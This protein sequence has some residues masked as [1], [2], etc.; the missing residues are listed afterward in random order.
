MAL[1]GGIDVESGVGNVL[2]LGEGGGVELEIFQEVLGGHFL[3]K[4]G[5]IQGHADAA[6]D[7]HAGGVQ[8]RPQQRRAQHGIAAHGVAHDK[9]IL[10]LGR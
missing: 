4:L 7:I 8:V 5:G 9:V 1:G 6:G 2:R 10:P 3:L